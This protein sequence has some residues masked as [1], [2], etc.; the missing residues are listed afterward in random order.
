[1]VF[2]LWKPKWTKTE[3]KCTVGQLASKVGFITY[4]KYWLIFA[5]KYY[6]FTGENV[7]HLN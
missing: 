3:S 4:Y 7:N 2:L 6:I 1:M 5:I